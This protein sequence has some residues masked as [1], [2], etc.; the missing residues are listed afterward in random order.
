MQQ[1]IWMKAWFNLVAFL[2]YTGLSYVLAL[3]FSP[4]GGINQAII[5]GALAYGFSNVH[6]VLWFT[7]Y[8]RART[9]AQKGMLV[10]SDELTL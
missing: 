10:G 8:T 9:E 4:E 5:G 2:L 1:Q 7:F 6:F 3:V